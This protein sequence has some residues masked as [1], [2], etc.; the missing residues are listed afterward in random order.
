MQ[1]SPKAHAI[2]RKTCPKTEPS[3]SGILDHT[4]C[5]LVGRQKE[6]RG[7]HGKQHRGQRAEG[8]QAT[9]GRGQRAEGSG[10]ASDLESVA[11]AMAIHEAQ[12]SVVVF[13]RAVVTVAAHP[14]I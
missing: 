12:T 7:P 1:R 5:L 10:D 14:V 8:R 6:K 4:P 2:A 13:E 11:D 9:Q 3:E